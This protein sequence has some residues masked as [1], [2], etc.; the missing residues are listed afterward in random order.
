MKSRQIR[1]HSLQTFAAGPTTT[2][3]SRLVRLPQKPHRSLEP[4]AA[5]RSGSDAPQTSCSALPADS[6]QASQI[7]MFGPATSFDTSLDGRSHQVQI[8]S[9]FALRVRRTRRHQVPPEAST[10]C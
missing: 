3:R 6:R 1:R 5:R 4:S 7:Q 8:A 2:E 10:I 9:R